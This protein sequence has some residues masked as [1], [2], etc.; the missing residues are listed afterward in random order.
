MKSVRVI[1]VSREFG[2]GGAAIGQQIA[3][4]LGWKLLDRDL[5]LEL[6]RRTHVQPSA[7]SAVDEHPSSFAANLLGSFWLG[8]IDPA[9]GLGSEVVDPDYLAEL[10][11]TV[12]REAATLGNWVIVGRGAQC[13]LQDRDDVF[14]V[15]VYGSR[16]ERLK[17]ARDRFPDRADREAALDEVDHTRAAYIRRYY[18]RDWISPQLYDLMISSDRGVTWAASVILSATQC[19]ENG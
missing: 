12:I 10:S 5:I 2:S 3:T 19:R 8:R 17:R 18:K 7:V 13:V 11:K 14:H 15:F 4:R 1:T 9:S 6:A 16:Q